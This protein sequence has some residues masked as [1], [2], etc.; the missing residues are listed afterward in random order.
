MFQEANMT[1]ERSRYL[2]LVTILSGDASVFKSVAHLLK[3]TNAVTP[4][5]TLK[6]AILRLYSNAGGEDLE[7]SLNDC[8]RS[9]DKVSNYLAAA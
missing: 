2:A 6:V 9:D 1:S 7:T 4:Y 3:T 8:V 5:S